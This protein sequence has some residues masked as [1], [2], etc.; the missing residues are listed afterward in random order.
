MTTQVVRTDLAKP[1]TATFD[2]EAARQKLSALTA[3]LRAEGENV[4]RLAIDDDSEEAEAGARLRE[5]KLLDKGLSEFLAQV[6]RPFLDV[7]QA[8]DKLSKPGRDDLAFLISALTGVLGAY[9]VRKLDARREAAAEAQ[10]AARARDTHAVTLALN[11][12]HDA[13]KQKLDGL[14]VKLKWRATVVDADAVPRQ[15]CEPNEAEI[16][17]HARAFSEKETPTPIDGVVFELVGGST[18]R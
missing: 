9:N 15:W 4:Q 14:S 12:K 6:K 13:G 3:G 17:R 11:A 5:I 10:A 2:V 18:L 1:I 7:T 8:V 16:Q